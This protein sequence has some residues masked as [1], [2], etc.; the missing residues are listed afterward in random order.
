MLVLFVLTLLVED[1]PLLGI[2]PDV[3]IAV[4]SVLAALAGLFVYTRQDRSPMPAALGAGLGLAGFGIVLL[5]A[6]AIVASFPGS[7]AYYHGWTV[8][9]TFEEEWNATTAKQALEEEGFNVTHAS[10]EGLQAHERD[11]VSVRVNVADPGMFTLHVTYSDQG[12][13]ADT[14]DEARDQADDA[15]PE[16]ENRYQAF[17]ESFEATTE[18]EH[19]DE[20]V[21]EPLIAVT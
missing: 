14:F 21:W 5:G 4:A 8:D 16:L 10:E 13:E 11:E 9:T 19:S 7:A 12:E 3:Q 2:N 6:M 1:R 17:L 18:W 20:P 15:R